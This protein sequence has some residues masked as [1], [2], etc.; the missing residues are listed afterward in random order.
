MNAKDKQEMKG[1]WE[2]NACERF[3]SADLQ[4]TLAF[5]KLKSQS[6]KYGNK[7][8]SNDFFLNCLNII[9]YT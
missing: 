7:S 5:Q 4:L 9:K 6:H 3:D 8:N 2:T 1:E